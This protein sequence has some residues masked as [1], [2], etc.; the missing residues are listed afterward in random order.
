MEATNVAIAVEDVDSSHY[1]VRISWHHMGI[2]YSI[3]LVTLFSSST[4]G[5][6]EVEVLTFTILAAVFKANKVLKHPMPLFNHSLSR[7]FKL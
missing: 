4:I 2:A 5:Q 1:I 3:T 7:K 6:D